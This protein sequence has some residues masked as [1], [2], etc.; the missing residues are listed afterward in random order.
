MTNPT[1]LGSSITVTSQPNLMINLWIYILS[2]ILINLS[3]YDFDI[4][5][6]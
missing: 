5:M 3:A 6:L 2:I 4:W 1:G